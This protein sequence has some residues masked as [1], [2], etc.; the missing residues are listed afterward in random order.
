MSSDVEGAVYD[1]E[2][3]FGL[4]VLPDDS[5]LVVIPVP[6][7]ATASYERGSAKGPDAIL[8]ASTQLDLFDLD[9]GRPYEIGIAMLEADPRVAAWNDE[10]RKLVD[11]VRAAHGE[12]P[13]ALARVTA[14]GDE[15]RAWLANET[16]RLLDGGKH[17]AVLGGDHSVPFGAIEALCKRYPGLGVLQIDAHADLRV[18][19]ENF[20]WSHASIMHNVLQDLDVSRLVQIGVRDLAESEHTRMMSDPRIT[21]VFDS[22]L[23]HQRLEG[24]DRRQTLRAAIETLPKAVYISFDIDGLDP[25]L[26]PHTGT[27]VPG[28]LS[29]DEARSVLTEVV[30]SG[31]RI[32]GFDLNEVA[33]GADQW[34]GNV[35]ARILYSLCGALVASHTR[36]GESS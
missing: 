6:F 27:P 2:G 17:V 22:S 13:R 9:F 11:Q 5:G 8:Q 10:A 32:V 1:N 3:L 26:C 31:R 18:S 28:G 36:S 14:I 20:R 21:P 24:G 29:F 35:G 33:P 34:D 23:A 4:G 25:S 19:Y 7:D 12:S 15:L 16:S 30:A